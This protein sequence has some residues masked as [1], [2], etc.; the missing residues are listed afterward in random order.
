MVVSKLVTI[1]V[2][3]VHS[4]PSYSYYLLMMTFKFTITH[5]YKH[6]LLLKFKS[7]EIFLKNLIFKF[8]YILDIKF[9]KLNLIFFLSK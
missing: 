1:L 2:Y 7:S 5:Y 6:L 8:P 3:L 9:M 4:L